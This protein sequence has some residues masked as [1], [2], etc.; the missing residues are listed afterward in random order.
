MADFN[1]AFV[2]VH[3]WSILD[4]LRETSQA[5]IHPVYVPLRDIS[6][7]GSVDSCAHGTLTAR[8]SADRTEIVLGT[9]ALNL[10]LPRLDGEATETTIDIPSFLD[11][12]TLNLLL[13][14]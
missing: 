2:A 14:S 8:Q 4:R 5:E 12:F 10:S 11:G 6:V 3:D 13:P 1:G 7:E 9:G